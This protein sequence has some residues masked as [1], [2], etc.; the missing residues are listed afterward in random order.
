MRVF[1]ALIAVLALAAPIAACGHK[2]PNPY[3]ES[4]RRDFYRQCPQENP[5]CSCTWE[6]LTHDMTHEEYQAAMERF[7]ETGHMEP[8]VTHARTVC[9]E[10]HGL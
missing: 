2:E 10:R 7:H 1:L 4:A 5:V 3:P 8:K 6:T 9:T